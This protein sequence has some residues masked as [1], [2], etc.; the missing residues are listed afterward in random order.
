MGGV[1]WRRVFAVV[2]TSPNVEKSSTPMMAYIDMIITM[3]T[4]AFI[5]PGTARTSA[6]ITLLSDSTRLNSRKTRKARSVLSSFRG[7]VSAPVEESTEMVTMKK[8]KIFH[9]RFARQDDLSPVEG[10]VPRTRLAC[11]TRHHAPGVPELA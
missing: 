9:L 10:S 7:P 8:S 5:T 1:G 3:I 11:A 2:R 4:K 6:R